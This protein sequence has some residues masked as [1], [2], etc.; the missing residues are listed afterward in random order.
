MMELGQIEST[1]ISW[2]EELRQ[3]VKNT[4]LD[5]SILEHLLLLWGFF[6]ITL[7]S[8]PTCYMAAWAA[9]YQRYLAG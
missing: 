4:G 1:T 6:P 8:S 2:T 9:F 7:S 3:A 5:N